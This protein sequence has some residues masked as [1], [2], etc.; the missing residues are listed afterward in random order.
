MTERKAELMAGLGSDDEAPK[1]KPRAAR[2]SAST[3]VPA[4]R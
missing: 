4:S 2:H 3:K 1:A